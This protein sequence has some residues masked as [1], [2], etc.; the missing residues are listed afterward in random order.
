[1]SYGD[2]GYDRYRLVAAL[3]FGGL[4]GLSADVLHSVSGHWL[5]PVL[6]FATG[7]GLYAWVEP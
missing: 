1:M 4:L 6:Y 7:V 3:T 5:I 2:Y